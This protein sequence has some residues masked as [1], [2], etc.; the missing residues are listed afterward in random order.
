[1]RPIKLTMQA[2]GAYREKTVLD[3]GELGDRSFFL[4]HGPTGSGKTTI[5]D[6]ICFALYGEASGQFRTSKTV[7]SDFADMKMR[8][9]VDLTFAV[10]KKIYRIERSPEQER[11]KMRGEGT[12]IEKPQATL[13]QI[14]DQ[15]E[16]LANGTR[17]VTEKIEALLGFKCDQ[18]RQVVLLPQGEFRKLLSAN[19]T[20]RQEIMKALFRTGFYERIEEHLKQKASGVK[21]LFEAV[22]QERRIVLETSGTADEKELAEQIELLVRQEREL[23]ARANEKK[24][25][26]IGK[27][28]ALTE[29]KR[30]EA[31]FNEAV[32]AKQAHQAAIEEKQGANERRN[33]WQTALRAE[34]LATSDLYLTQEEESGRKKRQLLCQAERTLE[35]AREMLRAATIVYTSEKEREP[36][37]ERAREERSRLDKLTES[38]RA[39]A[40]AE[41]ECSAKEQEEQRAEREWSDKKNKC[42]AYEKALEDLRRSREEKLLIAKELAVLSAAKER[43]ERRRQTSV[44]KDNVSREILAEEKMLAKMR[45]QVAGLERQ[46]R[47]ADT[48]YHEIEAQWQMAQAGVLASSLTEGAPCPVCGSVHHPMLAQAE[49]APSEEERKSAKKEAEMSLA[50]Y[51]KANLDLA[52][53]CAH[54]ESRRQRQAELMR[55]VGQ[56]APT[57]QVLAQQFDELVQK[58]KQAAEAANEAETLK[59]RIA[60][61]E[62]LLADMVKAR[63]EAQM[64]YQKTVAALRAVKAVTKER[65]SQVPPELATDDALTAAKER[66]DIQIKTLGEAWR[67]ADDAYQK[68]QAALAKAEADAISAREGVQ[69]QEAKCQALLRSLSEEIGVLGF[70]S[71]EAM[72]KAMRPGRWIQET[73]AYLKKIDETALAAHDRYIRAQ[74]AIEN[75]VRPDLLLL[76][77]EKQEAEDAYLGAV[78]EQQTKKDTIRTQKAHQKKIAE[79]AARIGELEASYRIVGQLAGVAGGN[80]EKKLT[81]QRYVL[82]ELLTEVA[83]VASVR[84]LKMSRQ[85]YTLRRTDEL[86]RKNAAGGLEL[87]VFDNLTGTARPVGT[88]SGGEGFLASLALALGLADVVQSY[89][90]G[91]RLDTMLIDEGF[92][93]LDP[94]MLDFAISTL[95]ELQRGGRLVGIISHVPELKERIDARLEVLQTNRGS[96]AVFHVG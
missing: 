76:T 84:L 48:H 12:M 41:K 19:S 36:Q 18:F 23:C 91:I 81:F 92:G 11:A 24:E 60:N 93:T 56:D 79:C 64:F 15:E 44:E 45:T 35:R 90:G 70:E 46:A 54:Q 62:R 5:L 69:E 95:L 94:E 1:M 71:R 96:T 40:Q 13:W 16:V 30:I 80:N 39:L 67:K 8:T 57:T 17:P 82:S 33:E 59:T 87:E 42:Q 85:R 55:L 34:K 78:K 4:I 26:L 75:S 50:S 74:K 65:R 53:R 61:G 66:A 89:A 68:A 25:I 27:E 77:R 58:E 83:Q 43:A 14:C 22:E 28:R 88:L 2:F 73:E 31:L 52:A 3:F 51:T 21:K 9:Y 20:E 86:T 29:G 37:R 47:E 10:G 6:A 49:K 72:R 32:S 63:D 38:V 7:R